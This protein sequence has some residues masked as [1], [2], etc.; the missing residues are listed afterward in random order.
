MTETIE[1]PEMVQR[2]DQSVKDEFNHCTTFEIFESAAKIFGMKY[3]RRVQRKLGG[4]LRAT[5]RLGVRVYL[6]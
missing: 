2:T 6:A 3:A 1:L 5:I 4:L